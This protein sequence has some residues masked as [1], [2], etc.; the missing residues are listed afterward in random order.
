[1]EAAAAGN[2]SQSVVTWLPLWNPMLIYNAN[3]DP[4]WRGGFGERKGKNCQA[5]AGSLTL[6]SSGDPPAASPYQIGDNFFIQKKGA[7][8]S[9]ASSL[10]EGRDEWRPKW[11]D[12]CG[13]MWF[14]LHIFFY[15]GNSTRSF[16]LNG[17]TSSFHAHPLRVQ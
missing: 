4:S 11:M 12:G 14:H 8:K 5:I 17:T 6:A 7:A 15:I 10:W 16:T 2:S 3:V 1:M 13:W 9:L